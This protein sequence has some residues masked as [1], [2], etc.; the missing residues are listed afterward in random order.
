M[1]INQAGTT[2]FFGS[3]EGLMTL[4]TANNVVGAVNI[5]IVGPVIS[6]SPDG[7]TLVMTDPNKKT[8]SLVSSSGN[9]NTTYGGVATRASWSPDAET[10]Y[11]TGTD[12]FGNPQLLVHSSAINWEAIPL[13]KAYTDVAVTVPH[14]GA[15]LAG[16]TFLDGRSYCP[17]S[18]A[19]TAV[20][21]PVVTNSFYPLADTE[22]TTIDR[23]AATTD[24]KH[25]IGA[26]ATAPAA[27]K[28]VALTLPVTK[29]CTAL[30]VGQTTAPSQTFTSSVTSYPLTGVVATSIIN[31]LPS[32]N[33]SL[34]FITYTGS[35][36][37]L[38]VYFP[39]ASGTGKLT[40]L[41]L[42]NG[43]TT[44]SAPVTGTFSTDNLTF[45]V[46]TSGDNQVHEI[47][48]NFGSP[49]G[50]TEAPGAVINPALPCGVATCTGT[51]MPNLIAQRPKK[52]TE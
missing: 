6:V 21:P 25:M 19:N 26:T 17:S 10:V 9:V 1:I 22:N 34:A 35:S 49:T 15:Y 51:A 16:G 12:E 30:Q 18:A 28:D 2:I 32:N 5:S 44:A 4:S 14:I 43:A 31:V 47:S 3:T 23:L 11:I 41:P 40:L 24:G 7:G 45:F 38:P 52:S 27:V 36:G 8:I 39:A 46:G 48:P 37:I 50:P 29:P 20:S 42:G 33:S 13:T